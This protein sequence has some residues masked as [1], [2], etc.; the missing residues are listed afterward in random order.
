M[1]FDERKQECI[2][3]GIVRG[4]QVRCALEPDDI[5]V[6]QGFDMWEMIF[7]GAIHD[8]NGCAIYSAHFDRYA[9]VITAAP[10][11]EVTRLRERVKELEG[12][13]RLAMDYV[14][15]FDLIDATG[16]DADEKAS[17]A[18]YAALRANPL[19]AKML[20]E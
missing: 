2:K 8:G 13:L 7:T 18:A 19:A 11:D 17:I 12:A 20:D 16:S 10:D 6:V 1:T 5:Y 15:A 3:R 14:K 4:A 9:E